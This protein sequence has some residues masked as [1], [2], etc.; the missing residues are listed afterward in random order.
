MGWKLP[1]WSIVALANAANKNNLSL[2][3]PKTY[4]KYIFREAKR[5]HLDPALIFAITRQESA[6]VTTAR[7]CAGALGLM[8]LIPSTAKMIAKKVHEPLRNNKDL[9]KADKNIKLGSKYLRVLLDKYQSNAVL[10]A[11]AYNA[12][13]ARIKNWLPE[14]DM[15]ADSWIETIP[16]K[17]TRN[18]VQ[19]VLTYTVIYQQI[20]GKKPRLSSHMPIISG[21]LRRK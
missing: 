10:A 20:L 21:S 19:N 6:F 15:P 9:L 5:N 3:F 12:G 11:A 4:S 18:Y 2:R 1:N 13:P 16:F 7:S 17:E 14:Y 8:Q